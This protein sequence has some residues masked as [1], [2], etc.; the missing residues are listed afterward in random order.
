MNGRT[1]KAS[2]ASGR[3]TPRLD[4]ASAAAEESTVTTTRLPDAPP[5]KP[6]ANTL[7]SGDATRKVEFAL[8]AEPGSQVF[9]A[10]TFNNWN[11]TATALADNPDSGHFKTTVAVPKGRHE[12]KFVV[13]GVWC[14]D[15]NCP[16]WAPNGHGSL[17][18]VIEV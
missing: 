7:T 9:L 5:A 18:S 3:G 12:Y 15:P 2:Y 10:G 8:N 14:V 4:P 16:D 1:R 13:N 6:R 11:P 17:N